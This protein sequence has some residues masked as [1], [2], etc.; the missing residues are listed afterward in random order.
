M[1]PGIA[2][3]HWR[4]WTLC[5]LCVCAYTLRGVSGGG[6]VPEAWWFGDR[7]LV[8]ELALAGCEFA[9]LGELGAKP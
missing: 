9:G 5:G 4:F 6:D 7:E 8:V 1:E 2:R 3:E